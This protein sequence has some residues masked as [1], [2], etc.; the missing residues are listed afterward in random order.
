MQ[1][2]GAAVGGGHITE[3]TGAV[4]GGGIDQLILHDLFVNLVRIDSVFAHQAGKSVLA[5]IE[6]G[7]QT[8]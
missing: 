4:G 1:R 2:L 7:A 3:L 5:H 8:S 6:F